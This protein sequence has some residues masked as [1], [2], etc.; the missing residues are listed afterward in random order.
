[1]SVSS[2]A[3]LRL[4]VDRADPIV[5]ERPV[6][7][8]VGQLRQTLADRGV[9]VEVASDLGGVAAGTR[10]VLVAGPLAPATRST[11]LGAGVVLPR[12]PEALALIPTRFDGQDVLL[13]TGSDARGIV[14]AVLELADR[15]EH[16]A[17][18]PLA[19]LVVP[20]PVVER[21]ANPIR[22]ITRL[23]C[24]D[25]EDLPWYLDRKGWQRY[26]TMLATH[27]Y[28]RV[29]IA[30]G[31]G[32]D[33]LRGVLDAY[34]LFAYPFLV[35]VPG[36]AVKAIDTKTGQPLPAEEMQRNLDTL[37]YV[38]EE[39]AARG[40]HFQLGIWT[41]G[42]EWAESPNA[43]HLTEG[44][45]SENHA[46]YCRDALR[47]VLQACPA[48]AGVTLR[49][50]GES[51]VTEGN[52]GFW[53]EVFQGV[54]SCG[55]AVELDLH[56]KG[57]DRAMIDVALK[58]G[59]E[60]NISPKYTAEHMGLP[61]HQLAIRPSEHRPDVAAVGAG[62]HFVENLMNR[63]AFDLRYTR[64]GYAD[65]LP[66]DRPYGVFYRIWPG[67]QRLLLWGDPALAAG[68]GREGTL[69]GCLG[70][71]VMEPLSFKG[72][73]GSG[74]PGGRDAYADKTL[75]P[76]GGAWEK[77]LYTFR[78][79]G[80]LLYNPN[81]DAD[82]WRRASLAELGTASPAAE[83]ALANASRILPL[84]TSAHMP[85]AANNRFWPEV[86]TNMPI[87]EAGRPNHYRDTPDPKRFGTVS[88]H[89]P[90]LFTTVEEYAD[91]LVAGHRDGRYSPL[92]VAAQLDA[93]AERAIALLADAR[94]ATPDPVAVEF[95]RLVADVSIQ[96]ALGRFF[97]AKLRAGVGYALYKRTDEVRLLA[98]AV[99]AYE[100]AQGAW[101]DAIT[102][103]QSY[104]DD[105]T[106]GGE[107][108]LRGHWSDRLAAI[109]DDLGD[110]RAELARVTDA[111]GDSSADLAPLT[112]LETP[113]PAVS[114]EHTPPATFER[115]QPLRV[116][117]FAE[118]D[119]SSL[120]VRLLCRPLNQALGYA[121]VEMEGSHGQF[122]GTIPASAT[123]T[124][125]PIQYHFELRDG[126]TQAWLY[127]GLDE[128]FSN[129][130]YVVVRQSAS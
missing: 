53:D 127:P 65:F 41:H 126:P 58:T 99:A 34:L 106:V 56:P 102:A 88:P 61:G 128:T 4:V 24:S 21:P 44:L 48:I 73:R 77:Y 125:Y 7:W 39:A 105:I 52:E 100:A 32:H 9:S 104:R 23:F 117:L 108:F 89:D 71:E 82:V 80:R 101:V 78:V 103:G 31:I 47:M 95:R 72:R 37:R 29:Q 68:I 54:A 98:E 113:P 96:T 85:S 27:R 110:M 111:A 120:T 129:R 66:E 57:V 46:A 79:F 62:D 17:G 20:E 36:Y 109:E 50:H 22:G 70:V 92:W 118:T 11:L 64:Y 25:V 60:V 18:D 6:Q 1:M 67:T 2:Q 15:A 130:P 14:Y 26:L 16:A 75:Q 8:A 40:I 49:V 51:G 122:Y 76:A 87:L 83:A 55:R 59:L 3:A 42:Y 43:S 35:D 119:T 124:P 123:D 63:S 19:A 12:G 97:A 84:L 114:Y 28:N 38:A 13:V 94:A 93:L 81:A 107:P 116:S 45:T 90:G 115:G 112:S 74:L 5:R 121:T 69:A 10:V 33:F 86:Y 30:F 91:Q